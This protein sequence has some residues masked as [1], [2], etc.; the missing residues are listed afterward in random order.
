[1][2]G[3]DK[4]SFQIKILI[5]PI[6][7]LT[8]DFFVFQGEPHKCATIF[9]DNSGIDIVLG[10]LPLVRQL[11]LQKT[12]VILCANTKPALNDITYEELQELVEQCCSKCK[13][14]DD[15][16]KT[17]LLQIFGNEQN[18]PCLDFRL[19]TQGLYFIS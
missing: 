8:D 4:G 14:I 11:L 3:K 9:T 15:A 2:V 6:E 5:R 12:K 16:Y 7:M 1:M 17:G 10:I 13:I 18:G 19:L